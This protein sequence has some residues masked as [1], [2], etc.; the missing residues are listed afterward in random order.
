MANHR[1]DRREFLAAGGSALALSLVEPR[2]LRGSQANSRIR[3]GLI[4]CGGRGT[5]IAD[6]FRNHGGYEFVAAADYF[7]DRVNAFGDKFSIDAGRRYTGLAGYRRLLDSPLDAV[8]IESPP[9]FHPHHADAAIRSGKHVYLAKPVAVDVPGCTTVAEAGRRARE[10]KLVFLVDFQTRA[11]PTFREVAKRVHYGEIG[12]IVNA[13]AVYYCDITFG[14]GTIAADDAEARLRSWGVDRALSGDIIV[15]QNIHAL[16]VA[17]WMLDAAPLS[18]VGTCGRT[19]RRGAGDGHDN[20]SALYNFPGEIALSFASKQCG[21]G[22]DDIGCMIFG[23]RGTADTHY[24]GLVRI[25][26]EIPYAGDTMK[27]LYTDGAVANIAE[28]HRCITAGEYHNRTVDASVRSNLTA[29]L[30][31]TAAYRRASVT[32]DD[33]LRENEELKADLRGLKD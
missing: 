16:D 22:Y 10:N 2:L 27:N 3:L 9:Y 21:Q 24:F 18:A 23:A 11:D 33:L 32:W 5:W 15:E 13:L 26:G 7:E 30:G 29:L 8:V 1:C 17:S 14:D 12:R 25:R 19:V 4:G 31:R 20:F 28:F 6:H